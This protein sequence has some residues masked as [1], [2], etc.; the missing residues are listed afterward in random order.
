VAAAVVFE[1]GLSIPGLN[2]SKLLSK[3]QRLKLTPAI[4]ENVAVF[5]WPP[6]PIR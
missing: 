6:F 1:T 3:S 2:D 4:I 5:L